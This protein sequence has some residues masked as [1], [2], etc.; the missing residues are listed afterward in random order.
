MSWEYCAGGLE[1]GSQESWTSELLPSLVHRLIAME[2]M[3][4]SVFGSMDR[5]GSRWSLFGTPCQR[6]SE[7][8]VR[9]ADSRSGFE[10]DPVSGHLHSE[11]GGFSFG[12]CTRDL[13]VAD[14]RQNGSFGTQ[15]TGGSGSVGH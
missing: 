9:G 3:I 13:V 8:G 1:A 14:V 12:F 7:K 15:S 11:I 2:K 5:E 4:G 6:V 10:S